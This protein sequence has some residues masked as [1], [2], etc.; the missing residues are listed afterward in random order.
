MAA[1]AT[2]FVIVGVVA[3]R[4]YAFGRAIWVYHF[5]SDFCRF[6]YVR[7]V[8]AALSWTCGIAGLAL[9]WLGLLPGTKDLG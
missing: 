3:F 8:P 4:A 6:W 5:E 7:P 1:W 9:G 2:G